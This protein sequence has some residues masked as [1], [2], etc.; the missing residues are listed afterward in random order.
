MAFTARQ[1]ITKAYYLSGIVSRK[2]QSVSGDQITDGLDFLN[3][4]IAEKAITGSM[5]PYFKEYSLTAVPGQ[6]EY[7]IPDLIQ[8]ETV[9]FNI[10]P[11]RYSMN[12]QGRKA[13]FGTGRVD[14]TQS[15][16]YQWHIER[17]LNGSTLYLYFIP[18][19]GYD[20]KIW[21]KFKL[22]EISDLCDDLELIYDKFYIK[23]L[24]YATANEI[25]D[26]Y[27]VILPVQAAKTLEILE[28]KLTYVSPL[29]LSVQKKSS[30]Q[31]D[32]SI[33]YADVNLG[34]GWRPA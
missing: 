2:F 11:V 10:G 12:V 19:D 30:F 29:D 15:L 1:L 23:Y 31:R 21:G 27:N 24:T 5:I 16:P 18:N 9:T 7:E 14:N 17:K 4:V 28:E 20:I 25:C 22:D 6:E 34:R 8:A 13:Y 32:T 33:N 3:E 26:E